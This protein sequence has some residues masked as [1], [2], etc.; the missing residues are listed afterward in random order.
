MA[1]GD[2]ITA[3][4]YITAQG[5]AAGDVSPPQQAQI[6]QAISWASATVRN[7]LDRNIGLGIVTEE[8]PYEYDGSGYL[9]I[10]DAANIT[11]VAFAQPIA[12][13]LVL[14]TDQWR[15]QPYEGPV[16]TYLVLPTAGSGW[17]PEMGFERNLD[18]LARE[19]RFYTLPPVVKVTADFGW[20]EVPE[21]V[22]QATVLTI[23]SFT[24]P[25]QEMQSES[26]EGYSYSRPP[27]LT[28]AA[29]A[30]VPPRAQDLLEPYVRRSL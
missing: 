23:M 21:P 4:E 2:L 30:A 24:S 14:T 26:I 27:R 5:I 22:K 29:L 9:D 19:G 8:R 15:A 20:P 3:D 16:Y 12:T 18:T 25:D 13:D 7:Y 6:D 1:A 10:D 28:Q 17:S 11:R